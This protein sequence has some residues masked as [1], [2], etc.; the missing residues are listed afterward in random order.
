V[1]VDILHAGMFGRI[2]DRLLEHAA[3]VNDMQRA[4]ALEGRQARFILDDPLRGTAMR[5]SWGSTRVCQVASASISSPP[6]SSIASIPR[7]ILTDGFKTIFCDRHG[8]VEGLRIADGFYR[9]GMCIMAPCVNSLSVKIHAGFGGSGVGDFRL[10]EQKPRFF[11]IG[12]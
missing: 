4:Q 3:R 12:S 5:R 10:T 2:G 9:S 1:Q 8:D 6:S 7:Q 11:G